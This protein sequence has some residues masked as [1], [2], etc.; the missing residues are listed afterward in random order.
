MTFR[1]WRKRVLA[2]LDRFRP[3]GEIEEYGRKDSTYC[4]YDRHGKNETTA[5]WEDR[6]GLW[7][8]WKLSRRIG[9]S[10]KWVRYDATR[11]GVHV[12][13][14]WNRNFDPAIIVAMQAVLGSDL[15][16]ESFN[17]ARVI[18]ESDYG[19]QH[20]KE[21]ARWNILYRMKLKP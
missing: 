12:V 5:Q 17:L 9:T 15:E 4:D 10:P 11:C 6:I 3:W 1:I 2:S 18:A 7:R 13:T 14:R 19:G 21:A 8:V 20:R 16:R